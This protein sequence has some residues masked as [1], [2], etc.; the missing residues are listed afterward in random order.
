MLRVSKSTHVVVILLHSSQ[1]PR[2]SSHEPWWGRAGGIHLGQTEG[3][4]KSKEKA[5]TQPSS[6][7][8]PLK[9]WADTWLSLQELTIFCLSRVSHWSLCPTDVPKSLGLS[10]SRFWERVRG[11]CWVFCGWFI[12]SSLSFPS[13]SISYLYYFSH[14]GVEEGKKIVLWFETEVRIH[15]LDF[16]FMPSDCCRQVS[17]RAILRP[18]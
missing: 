14:E 4:K 10:R 9:L 12:F 18:P 2:K 6:Y 5:L 15:S 1:S 3:G 11:W 16:I 8:W 7:P 17:Y 13:S